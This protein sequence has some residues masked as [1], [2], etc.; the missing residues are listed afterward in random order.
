[1]EKTR[2]LKIGGVYENGQYSRLTEVKER[3]NQMYGTP[4]GLLT[5]NERVVLDPNWNSNGRILIRQDNPLPCTVLATIPE[6][7]L[8]A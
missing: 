1:M 6:V 5:G 8:G 2:G 3:S 4:I 7:D